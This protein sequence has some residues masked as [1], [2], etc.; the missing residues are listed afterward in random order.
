M[1]QTDVPHHLVFPTIQAA[2]DAVCANPGLTEV[3]V[4]VDACVPVHRSAS[5]GLKVTVTDGDGTELWSRDATGGVACLGYLKNGRQQAIVDGLSAALAQAKGELSLQDGSPRMNSPAEALQ[6]ALKLIECLLDLVHL[7]PD[8]IRVDIDHGTAC[9][10][11]SFVTL[12]PGDGLLRLAAAAGAGDL[13][14][15]L[16]EHGWSISQK[17][18]PSS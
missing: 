17:V 8:L 10:G 6:R 16:V 1:S 14:L 18:E 13:D 5:D 4:D 2:F 12:K 3:W 11:E 7:T 15:G 9:A